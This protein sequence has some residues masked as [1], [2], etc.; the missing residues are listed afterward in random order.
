VRHTTDHGAEES[1]IPLPTPSHY[2]LE[3]FKTAFNTFVA[4]EPTVD[5]PEDLAG[6]TTAQMGLYT[7]T[8]VRMTGGSYRPGVPNSCYPSPHQRLDEVP[9]IDSSTSLSQCAIYSGPSSGLYCQAGPSLVCSTRASLTPTAGCCD[10]D[11][12]TPCIYEWLSTPYDEGYARIM[13]PWLNH[14]ENR[15]QTV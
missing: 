1:Q 14:T 12:C 5:D 13:L 9:R 3:L 8:D 7:H 4:D 6:K 11:P 10:I 2:A 15:C